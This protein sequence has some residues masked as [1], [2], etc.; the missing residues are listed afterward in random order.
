MTA[1]TASVGDP[2][3]P[4]LPPLQLSPMP[5][6]NGNANPP[7]EFKRELFGVG[8]PPACSQCSDDSHA[9]WGGSDELSWENA[10]LGAG[11]GRSQIVGPRGT[12]A[13]LHATDGT[14]PNHNHPDYTRAVTSTSHC[15]GVAQA[16]QAVAPRPL[17][18]DNSECMC[19]A[20]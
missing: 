11:V 5:S 1:S 16:P 6:E 13:P 19:S 9:G 2:L 3:S 7:P 15:V 10:L 8:D 20:S 4:P 17:G 14:G 18:P 12:T